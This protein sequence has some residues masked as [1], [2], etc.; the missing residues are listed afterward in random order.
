MTYLQI[1]FIDNKIQELVNIFWISVI[2]SLKLLKS[3]QNKI[4]N[5]A[6]HVVYV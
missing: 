5:V 4:N 6:M 1:I 3:K 2:F